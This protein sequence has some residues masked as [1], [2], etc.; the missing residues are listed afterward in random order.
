MPGTLSQDSIPCFCM[1]QNGVHVKETEADIAE[2]VF[3]FSKEQHELKTL[4]AFY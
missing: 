1:Y 2:L 3:F 4:N